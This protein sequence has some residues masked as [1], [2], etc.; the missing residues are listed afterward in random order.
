MARF[1]VTCWPFV[2]HV[3]PQMS[4]AIALRDRG[5]EIAFYTGET[6]RATIEPHGFEVFPFQNVNEERAYSDIRAV[7]TNT[8][9][10]RSA[11]RLTRQTFREWLVETIP[12]QLA[13]LQP[14]LE[15]WDP[16]V[17]I[18]DLSMWG[19]IVILWETTGI[20]VALS[21]TFMGPLIAGKDVPPPGLGLA[22]P[23]SRRARF[24]AAALTRAGDIAATGIRRR[25]DELR[26][27]HG[28]PPMGCSVTEFTARLPLYLVGNLPELDYNRQDIPPSVHYVGPCIWHPSD[29]AT[30]AGWLDSIPTSHPWVHVTESTLRYGDPFV[31]RAAAQGLAGLP[32]EV[33]MTTGHHRDAGEL[34]LGP[35]APNIHVS[36]WL[37]HSD[38]LPR[39]AAVVTTGGPAT[40]M[41]ALRVGVPLVVVPTTWD[42]PDNAQRVVEA[43]VGLRVPPKRCTPAGLRAVVGELLS[44]PGYRANAQAMAERLNAAPGSAKAAELLES[45]VPKMATVHG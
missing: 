19:P 4:I 5:H 37:S 7:E 14:I 16:D 30:T 24:V 45:L 15:A 34:G 20:P 41:A 9:T 6:A 1:L 29:D 23:K 2:G 27:E 10:G 11:L 22:S 36:P 39:C 38:L 3:F 25:V 17:I 31:L 8:A 43:G 40:V 44:N 28:L 26:A 12:N 18:T 35:L 32:M 13:D 33:I 42:K 21:S